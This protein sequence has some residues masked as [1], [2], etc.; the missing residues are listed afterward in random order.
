MALTRPTFEQTISTRVQISDPVVLINHGSPTDRDLGLL[1]DRSHLAQSNIAI[2]FKH[3]DQTLHFISTD[4]NGDH[5]GS[6]AVNTKVDISAGNITGTNVNVGSISATNIS[7]NSGLSLGGQVTG[8]IIPSANVIYNLGSSTN[9]FK[10]IWLANSTIYLGNV[11]LSATDTNLSINGID[12][13]PLYTLSDINAANVSGQVANALVAGTVYTNSQPNI[14]SLGTLTSL[15]VNGNVSAGNLSGELITGTLATAAQPNITS[16]GNLNSLT[17]VGNLGAGNIS[18]TVISG[19]LSTSSQPNITAVGSLEALSVIGAITASSISANGSLLSQITAANVNGQVANAL[20]SGTVYA[21]S[22]PNITSLGTLTTLTV[23]GNITTSTGNFI[24]NGA[25]LTGLPAGYANSNVASYLPTYSGNIGGTLTTAAQPFVTSLGTLTSLTVA[26]NLSAGNLSGTLITGTL[27]T[28]AQP[29][30]T[31][32]GTLSSLTVTA[33]VTAA[34]ASY[35]GNVSVGNLLLTGNIVDTAA[36]G[37]NSGSNGNITLNA[38]SGSIVLNSGVLN[39]QANGVGNIGSSTSFFNTVFARATSAQYAD[40]AEIYL[41]DD[42]YEPGTVVVFGGA[43]EITVTNV[44]HDSR[45]AGVIST[46]P[47]YLM[48]SGAQ[49]LAVALTG[50]VPCKVLGPVQ[51]GTVLTTSNIPGVAEALMRSLYQPGCVIGKSLENVPAG[52]TKIIEVV[53]GRF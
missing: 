9:R 5:I 45:V 10:D 23:T 44:G 2:V 8:N 30:I 17:V 31:S 22:Q 33:N 34:A 42:N 53:V 4:N 41:A 24:G 28:A 25:L 50:R 35:T 38:G 46:A 36:L 29:N 6:F 20:V 18:T 13:Q 32:V 27:T 26:A 49:G 19:T 48:N 40:L 12:V 52:E 43:K 7:A 21:N 39:G 14:T 51:K 1:F 37:I 3:A 15:T 11:S 16:L 47:A